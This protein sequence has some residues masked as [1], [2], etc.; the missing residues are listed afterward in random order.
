MTAPTT[1]AVLELSLR[2]PPMARFR[3]RSFLCFLS[4]FE[5][6]ETR[7]SKAERMRLTT[8]VTLAARPMFE[9]A[10]HVVEGEIGALVRAPRFTL[11]GRC[12][13][14]HDFVTGETDM[15]R[16]ME[17]I[18]IF[19]MVPGKLDRDMAGDDSIVDVI[20]PRRARCEMLGERRGVTCRA[21]KCEL[22]GYLH[23]G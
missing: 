20:E 6:L 3:S 19:V 11:L 17:T 23:D 14:D 10:L 4:A 1:R 7:L 12:V 16:K 15:N 2:L 5:I 18:S 13:I 8:F 9:L 21:S 22:K